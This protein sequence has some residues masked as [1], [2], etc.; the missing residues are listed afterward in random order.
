MI[1]LPCCFDMKNQETQAHKSKTASNIGLGLILIAFVILI[2]SVT[3][4]KL[5][6]GNTIQGFDHVLRPEMIGD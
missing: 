2:F 4:V 3:I 6:R 1:F 5:S